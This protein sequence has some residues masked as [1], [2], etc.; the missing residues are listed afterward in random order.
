MRVTPAAGEVAA[1]R[2]AVRAWLDEVA[3]AGSE[4]DDIV[5]IVSEL[6]A[7]GVIHAGGLD[8]I[9]SAW[10][11]ERHVSVE[12]ITLSGVTPRSL[13]ATKSGELAEEGRG[14]AIVARLA[15]DVRLCVDTT[16]W[17]VTCTISLPDNPGIAAQ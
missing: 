2:R 7:N 16:R 6:V 8:I 4:A 1:V 5:M 12:V 15:R 10:R 17:V 13:G 9:V 11:R 3:V 14:L